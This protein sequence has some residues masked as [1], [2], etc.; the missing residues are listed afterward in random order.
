MEYPRRACHHARP[1]NSWLQHTKNE[2]SY[3]TQA[4]DANPK[5]RG[6]ALGLMGLLVVQ[7]VLGMLS[8]M[9]VSFPENNTD[10]QQWHYA[11]GQLLIVAHIVVGMALLLGMIVLWVRAMKLRDKAWKI[12]GGLGTGSV[13]LAIVSGSEFISNQKDGYSF[14]MS[15]F[16]IT[17]VASLGWGIYKTKV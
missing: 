11:E 8:N 1:L 4:M 7:Y 6:H 2:I 5:L 10:W 15:L 16:F 12:A 13:V 3:Y 9:Y 14:A 17:A